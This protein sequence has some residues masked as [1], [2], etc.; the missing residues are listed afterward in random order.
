MLRSRPRCAG[1]RPSCIGRTIFRAEDTSRIVELS[2]FVMKNSRGVLCTTLARRR[3]DVKEKLHRRNFRPR[4]ADAR[5][6]DRTHTEPNSGVLWS[7]HLGQEKALMEISTTHKTPRFT[8]PPGFDVVRAQHLRWLLNRLQRGWVPSGLAEESRPE[9]DEWRKSLC[10]INELEAWCSSAST[11][12]RSLLF[13][14]VPWDLPLDKELPAPI[15]LIVSLH[16]NPTLEI[17]VRRGSVLAAEVGSSSRTT[18]RFDAERI[19]MQMALACGE[20]EQWGV[21]AW[22]SI[23]QNLAEFGS[24]LR[25]V[26]ARGNG[27]SNLFIEAVSMYTNR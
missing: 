16:N 8:E 20:Q 6:L 18:V 24:L 19:G 11:L 10:T 14:A 25:L 9:F 15:G 13:D 23:T 26:R 21:F 3:L 17:R 5:L 27:S 12:V 1:G 2:G 4:V 7:D 22:C